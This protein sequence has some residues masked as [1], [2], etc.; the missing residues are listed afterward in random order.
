MYSRV[1]AAPAVV[2][3]VV[4][5]DSEQ[6]PRTVLI[7]A[8]HG[9]YRTFPFIQAAQKQSIHTLIA[10]EGRHSVVSAYAQGI[11]IDFSDPA[12]A[13]SDLMTAVAAKNIIAVV[14][15]D[16]STTEL[17]ASVARCLQ[18]PHNDPAA[19]RLTQRKDKARDALQVHHVPKPD[20]RRL[21]LSQDCS[22]QL[23]GLTFPVVVKPISLSASRGVIRA[24]NQGELSQAI[25]RIT[26]LLNS[27]D[28]L[29]EQERRYL[30]IEQFIP[31]Y[32]VAV[33]AMLSDGRLDILAIFDKPDAMNG[34][35]F[36]ETYYVTPSRLHRDIQ[37]SIRQVIEQACQAYGLTEGPVHAECRVNEQGVF[38]LE[39]A[40]RTIGGLC[41]R[42]L[43]F[44]TGL[45][46]EELVLLHAMGKPLKSAAEQGAAGVLMIPIPKA[47][48]LKR[49]EGL[50]DA[51]R[52]EGIEEVNI[53]IREGHELV[54]L[55]EGASYLGFIFARGDTPQ[56]VEA[57]LRNAH[58]KLHFVIAP[59][60]KLQHGNQVCLA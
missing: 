5:V 26:H 41:G 56:Q 25:S 48:L 21:D 1:L 22:K 24:N 11:H 39:V 10:S 47:G 60:W 14:A 34:P 4:A 50:L 29:N 20:H 36:E 57:A 42:L 8:P 9:S 44:G 2:P 19:V 54:P 17:A 27:L 16:D 49:V 33:E 12:K 58:S 28:D 6:Q 13:F 37:I 30:L 40:A 7:I 35:F 55:P 46:L 31:G 3:D 52:V 43:R 53:Q 51:Q 38:I 45:S 59:V 23:E 18:L 15:T 32:E